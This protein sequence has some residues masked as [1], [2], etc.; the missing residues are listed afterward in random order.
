MYDSL[1][2]QLSNRCFN[3]LTKVALFSSSGRYDAVLDDQEPLYDQIDQTD[4]LVDFV[5]LSDPSEVFMTIPDLSRDPSTN[6]EALSR[7][8]FEIVDSTSRSLTA[9]PFVLPA[10]PYRP[11]ST[12][13][14]PE[15]PPLEEPLILN[16][17][18][19][20]EFG[21]TDDEDFLPKSRFKLPI[22]EQYD[23]EFG[24]GKKTKKKD[25]N[26]RIDLS[27]KEKEMQEDVT[28]MKQMKQDLDLERMEKTASTVTE[29]TSVAVAASNVVEDSLF[30]AVTVAEEIK[31]E[32]DVALSSFEIES[33]KTE[34]NQTKTSTAIT[35]QTS[36]LIETSDCKQSIKTNE[37]SNENIVKQK[38]EQNSIDVIETC[39]SE[40]D[41]SISV[42]EENKISAAKQEVEETIVAGTVKRLSINFDKETN[43]STMKEV[44]KDVH[45]TNAKDT[46]VASSKDTQVVLIKDS[47]ADTVSAQKYTE[48]NITN[49][50]NKVKTESKSQSSARTETKTKMSTEKLLAEQR[51][52]T[53]GLQTIPNIRGKVH[54]SYHYNLLLKTFFIHLTDVMVALSRFILAEPVL[55]FEEEHGSTVKRTEQESIIQRENVIQD[56]SVIQNEKLVKED[57]VSREEYSVKH[58]NEAVQE[59][60]EKNVVKEKQ[61]DETELTEK[62][63]V[64][65]SKMAQRTAHKSEELTERMDAVITEFQSKAGIDESSVTEQESSLKQGRSQIKSKIEEEVSKESDPLEWLSKKEE[66]REVICETVKACKAVEEVT[67]SEICATESTREA[68]T[69]T[70]TE[71]REDRHFKSKDRNT[72]VAIVESHVYTNHDAILEEHL[73]GGSSALNSADVK[74]SNE[75]IFLENVQVSASAEER[76]QVTKEEVAMETAAV[77]VEETKKDFLEESRNVTSTDVSEQH[78]AE[79]VDKVRTSEV[80]NA[81]ESTKMV[82]ETEVLKTDAE[83]NVTLKL[84]PSETVKE[85]TQVPVQITKET[86][87]PAKTITQISSSEETSMISELRHESKTSTAT[88]YESKTQEKHQTTHRTDVN[89]QTHEL[90]LDL[91]QN[92]YKIT[93]SDSFPSTIDTPTPATIPPTP[94]TDEYLF[95]LEIPMPKNAGLPPVEEPEPNPEKET[96]HEDLGIVKKKWEID[97]PTIESVVYDPPLPTPL[98]VKDAPKFSNGVLSDAGDDV[99]K[100]RSKEV[101]RFSNF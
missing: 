32:I 80:E 22:S 67:Q 12:E 30:K 88:K 10:K 45:K 11:F 63:K 58:E 44:K 47:K 49:K 35:E 77:N 83:E 36:T 100:V 15:V 81:I 87:S 37:T 53:I 51:A 89:Q 28:F 70:K 74:E 38:S 29:L 72:Y 76:K 2:T 8:T 101:L 6:P 90:S 66:A 91:K 41:E 16:P 20:D 73:S 27:K 82:V 21:A 69:V 50:Q 7:E 26:M 62:R 19:H 92:G 86:T 68:S 1:F 52:Y 99:S 85:D 3:P 9:S 39:H 5:P 96:D 18:Y 14:I 42:K 98:E 95:R 4:E 17:D 57:V 84:K 75:N 97:S 54:S 94:L 59:Y 13:P 24:T 60:S 43:T 46:Q 78:V 31:K 34:Q 23:P 79:T 33:N 25:G 64:S 93:H 48:S 61:V 55:P 40:R 65:G 71:Q 56:E